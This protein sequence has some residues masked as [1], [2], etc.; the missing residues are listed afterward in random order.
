MQCCSQALTQ[1]RP[2]GHC[3]CL[4]VTEFEDVVERYFG[5]FGFKIISNLFGTIVPASGQKRL[6]TDPILN[7]KYL[8]L[9]EFGLEKPQRQVWKSHRDRQ[10]QNILCQCPMTSRTRAVS[11][12]GYPGTID[13]LNY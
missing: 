4:S 11:C 9:G 8:S 10:Q 6:P 7:L 1:A 13:I 5:Y 12:D 2:G 3:H